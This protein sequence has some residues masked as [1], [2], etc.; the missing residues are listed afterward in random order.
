MRGAIDSPRVRSPYMAVDEDTLDDLN[1]ILTR[2]NLIKDK[3]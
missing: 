2:L 1:D 3:V